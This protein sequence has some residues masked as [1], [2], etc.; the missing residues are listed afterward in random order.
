MPNARDM[1][2]PLLTIAAHAIINQ[3]NFLFKIIPNEKKGE[4]GLGPNMINA[5]I[6]T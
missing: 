4:K 6:T 3:R 5:N 1:P 2:S